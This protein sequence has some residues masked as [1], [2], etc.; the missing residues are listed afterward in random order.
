[1]SSRQKE[2]EHMQLH[3]SVLGGNHLVLRGDVK[4]PKEVIFPQ[5]RP[6][7]AAQKQLFF[8]FIYKNT[9]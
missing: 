9:I 7:A 4:R 1:M 5:L 6:L 2:A 3:F 8:S